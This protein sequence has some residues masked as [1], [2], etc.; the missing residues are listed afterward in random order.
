MTIQQR[1]TVLQP[2]RKAHEEKTKL[3]HKVVL[4]KHRQ[5]QRFQ[6]MTLKVQQ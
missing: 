3:S 4:K 2:T 6:A 5:G 1:S